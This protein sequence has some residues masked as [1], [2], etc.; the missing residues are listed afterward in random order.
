[1]QKYIFILTLLYF[2]LN[3]PAQ[4]TG[5][6]ESIVM[7]TDRDVYVAG[8]RLYFALNLTNADKESNSFAY[9]SLNNVNGTTVFSGCTVIVSG[10]SF[11]TIPLSDTL[12]SGL[13][14]L[15][16]FTN[17]LRN[18]G[19][20]YFA[21][22]S[23]LVINRFDSEFG[24]EK[25]IAETSAQESGND[26]AITQV[27]DNASEI[28]T[29]NQQ[30]HRREK[31]KV[32]LQIPVTQRVISITV[33]QA[34]PLEFSLADKS[35]PSLTSIESC[36][37]LPE[38]SGLVIQGTINDESGKES[39]GLPVYLS[40]EDSTANLQYTLTG[41]DGT[42]RFF[43]NPWYFG[44]TIR[45]KPEN[46]YQGSITMDDKFS[47]ASGFEMPD[48]TVTGNIK[49]FAAISQ[50]LLT[51]RKSYFDEN[52]ISL[53]NTETKNAY[54]PLVYPQAA[55]V[56]K[57]SEFTYLPDFME[58]SREILPFIKTRLS[59]GEY[60]VSVFDPEKQVYNDLLVFV[61]GFL[62]ENIGQ[63]ISLDSRKIKK[64]EIVT[65]QRYL[66]EILIPGVISI[67]TTNR[68]IDNINWSH[69]IYSMKLENIMKQEIPASIDV[70]S[71]QHNIPDFRQ[72]LYW[73]PLPP[74][75]RNKSYK[76]ETMTSDCTGI[77]EIVVSCLGT[78]GKLK[79][80]K[81]VFEVIH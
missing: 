76:F 21:R 58:I 56:I 65:S 29:D 40:C 69:P 7:V 54:R 34:A 78:N 46:D 73:N 17:C 8:D 16:S 60:K 55:R 61:D 70:A 6:V 48:V 50:K 52:C 9:I 30:Y 47:S 64:I 79:E 12:E 44:K 31:V 26:V 39:T 11:G 28:T 3:L 14:Q 43:L 20:D 72:L 51:I 33:R 22:K 63:V 18:Y 41:A 53:T 13:Y 81:K 10:N 35:E 49:Q 62:I 42:F 25:S 45:I 24:F 1:M 66:G 19:R 2:S 5:K 68:E 67:T 38:K 27:S 71:L 15:V 37:Y 74:A 57:P 23:I 75:D 4:D 77:F 32:E 59:S 80:Y 36:R